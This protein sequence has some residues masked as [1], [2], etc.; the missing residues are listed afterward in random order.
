V[1][2]SFKLTNSSSDEEIFTVARAVAKST[3]EMD[4]NNDG[5]VSFDE[6]IKHFTANNGGQ[7]PSE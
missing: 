6:M 1:P 3:L 4:S 2:N 7:E 5:S